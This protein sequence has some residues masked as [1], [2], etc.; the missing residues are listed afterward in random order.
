MK[1][2]RRFFILSFCIL[3][4]FS[5]FADEHTRFKRIKGF[6]WNLYAGADG[7]AFKRVYVL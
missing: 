4:S 1:V 7:N 3:L 5:L 6:S 2:L